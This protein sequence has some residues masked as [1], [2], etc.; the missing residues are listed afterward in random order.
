MQAPGGI[1]RAPVESVATTMTIA[2]TTRKRVMSGM[3]ASGS[4]H[5]GHLF[6]VLGQ[7]ARYCES[8]EAYFEIADLHG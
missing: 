1:D 5:L 8:A 2:A 4:L 7:W 6:G 3:R